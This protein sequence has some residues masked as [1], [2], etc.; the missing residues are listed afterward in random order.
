MLTL[1]DIRK[2][3]S[4]VEVLHGVSFDISEGCVTAL[5]GENG[6]GKSTLVNIVS[7]VYTDYSGEMF[8]DGR[9]VLFK[10]PRDAERAGISIIHQEL[11]CIP[12]LT[13]GENILL[14]R[15]PLRYRAFIDFPRLFEAAQSTLKE[16][17]FPYSCRVKVRA[18][19]IGLQQIVEIARAFSTDAKIIILDEPTSALTKNEIRIL[20]EKIRLLRERGKTI[21]FISHQLEEVFEIADIVRSESMFLKNA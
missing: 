1:S 10:S 17:D 7:G 8:L 19:S 5:V 15:E 2:S 4:G 6:A 16:F 3:F 12:D 13:V 20:F 14:G 18:I 21:L 11:S 9:K